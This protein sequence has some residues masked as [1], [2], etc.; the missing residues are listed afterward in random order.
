M[1]VI[2]QSRQDRVDESCR[3]REVAKLAAAAFSVALIGMA[4]PALATGEISCTNGKGGGVDLLVSHL[5]VLVVSRVTV[6]LGGKFWSSTT[7]S[8]PGLPISLGQA[9][10]DDKQLLVDIM[11]EGMGEVIG[12]LRVFYASEGEKRVAGG[13]FAFKGEGAFVVDCSE[14]E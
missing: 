12:R 1:L 11:D 2:R 9:F 7:E 10:Q 5:D 6:N 3:R 13:V 14:P 4:T 8:M